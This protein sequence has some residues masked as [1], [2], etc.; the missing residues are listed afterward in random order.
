MEK[1]EAETVLKIMLT[2][3]SFCSACQGDLFAQFAE[4]FPEHAA[5]AQSIL[6]ESDAVESLYRQAYG[7]WIDSGYEGPE[8]RSWR[9]PPA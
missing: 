1:G 7:D 8:P 5:L 4:A 2:A 6:A 9:T 3:D